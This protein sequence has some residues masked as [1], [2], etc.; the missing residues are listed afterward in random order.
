MQKIISRRI[1]QVRNQVRHYI[2]SLGVMYSIHQSLVITV[3]YGL[4]IY[5]YIVHGK[6][7]ELSNYIVD[8]VSCFGG[9][10]SSVLGAGSA[11]RYLIKPHKT[12]SGLY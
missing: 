6:F 10:P 11:L 7:T 5:F 3:V 2:H 12:N 1:T 8:Y 4:L 9:R